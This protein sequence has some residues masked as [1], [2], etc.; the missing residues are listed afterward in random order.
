MSN[1]QILDYLNREKI[2]LGTLK[3][4]LEVFND[5]PNFKNYKTEFISTLSTEKNYGDKNIIQLNIFNYLNKL[6]SSNLN[7]YPKINRKYLIESW[8]R[9]GNIYS[10][11]DPIPNKYEN[12]VIW[13]NTDFSNYI[14]RNT[15]HIII[16]KLTEHKENKYLIIICEKI[17]TDENKTDFIEI[18]YEHLEKDKH[19]KSIC[20]LYEQFNY[21]S[22]PEEY[23]V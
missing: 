18:I 14:Y 22:V 23:M 4:I 3:C 1:N 15:E 19:G 10:L 9:N 16:A 12:L 20:N 11:K 21:N 6:L 13:L 7:L 17:D 8:S 5:P 2:I